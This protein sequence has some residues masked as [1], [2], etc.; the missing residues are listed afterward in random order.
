[1]NTYS[2]THTETEKLMI[3]DFSGPVII[4]YIYSPINVLST[5]MVEI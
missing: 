2:R 4:H 3:S 1:M 5:K